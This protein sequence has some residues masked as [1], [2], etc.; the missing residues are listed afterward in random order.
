MLEQFKV[1]AVT[2]SDI[3][4]TPPA[5]TGFVQPSEAASRISGFFDLF[6]IFAAIL[7]TFFIIRG[8]IDYI[9]SGG[10][11]QKVKAAQGA[12]QYSI[13]GLIVVGVAYLVVS[14]VTNLLGFGTSS[15]N[16]PV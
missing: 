7:A 9:M 1:K 6:F 3:V 16:F 11:A 12:I 10:E 2:G 4:G 14:L 8:G 5:V 13:I 15:L